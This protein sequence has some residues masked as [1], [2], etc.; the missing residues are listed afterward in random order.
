MVGAHVTTFF[1][2]PFKHR[3][4]NNPEEVKFVAVN[5]AELFSNTTTKGTKGCIR[6][7]KCIRHKENQILV[8]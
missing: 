7:F 1:F 5:Q 6:H 8:F 2:R 4:V 3:P